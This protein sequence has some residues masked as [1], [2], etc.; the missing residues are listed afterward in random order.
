MA[1]KNQLVHLFVV[2]EQAITD[3]PSADPVITKKG[4]AVAAT[5]STGGRTF[6]MTGTNLNEETLRRLI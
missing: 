5:W 1:D 4:N 2:D 6:F 3:P